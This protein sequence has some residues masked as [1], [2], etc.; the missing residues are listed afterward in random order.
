[1]LGKLH[2]ALQ[3]YWWFLSKGIADV[4]SRAD[5]LQAAETSGETV[6]SFVA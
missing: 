5:V 1:M 6:I 2:S 3:M 4:V